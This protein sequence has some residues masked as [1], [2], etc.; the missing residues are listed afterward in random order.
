VQLLL[1]PRSGRMVSGVAIGLAERYGVR[2]A[3]VRAIFVA[4]FLATPL[5]VLL[6]LLLAISMPSEISVVGQLS[7]VSPDDA[8]APRERFERFSQLLTNR[9]IGARTVRWIPAYIITIWLVA[10]A[11]LLELPSVGS[12][13]LYRTHPWVSTLAN[14]IS[15]SGTALFFISVGVLFLLGSKQ[16]APIATFERPSRDTFSCD[17]SGGKMIGGVIS[18]ISQVLELDPAYLRALFIV[19]NILTMGLAGAAYL[20]VWYLHRGKDTMTAPN[21]IEQL[22]IRKTERRPAFHI[23]MAL[24]FILLAGI[25]FATESRFYFFNEAFVEGSAMAL[26]GIAMVWYGVGA[27]RG[28]VKLWIVG[29]AC[30]FFLGSY[31]LASAIGHLQI[32]IAKHFEVAEIIL[33]LS[34]VYLG[35]VSLRGYARTLGF[36]VAGVLALSAL[37][38]ATRFTPPDYLMELVRFYGFFYPIIFAGFGLWIAFEK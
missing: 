12:L 20:L 8:L 13:T 26:A 32:S 38:I 37:C 5:A 24:L 11:A 22:S 7:L 3:L 15:L 28:R 34:M 17:R 10:F 4:A 16:S 25:H 30:I 36:G 35:I 9:L 31:Q 14:D 6:Y 21:D 23:V 29:G 2:T 33:A 27:L 18:G 1:R 19:L